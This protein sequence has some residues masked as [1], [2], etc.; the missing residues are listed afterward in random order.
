MTTVETVETTVNTE[1]NVNETEIPEKKHEMVEKDRL[2]H[3]IGDLHKY[4]SQV[5]YLQDKLAAAQEN[6][7]KEKENWKTLY[8]REKEARTL[9]EGVSIKTQESYLSEKKFSA[10]KE[11]AL[12]LGLRPEALD[13]LSLLSL[14]ELQIETTSTGRINVLGADTAVQELKRTRPYWF[15][16]QRSPNVNTTTVGVGAQEG[17]VTWQT[18]QKLEREGKKSGDMLKYREAFSIYNK[19]R[20]G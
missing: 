6:E 15:S 18:L 8:E 19:Q 10:M 9:A 13:D 17:P 16:D 11:S 4:K 2:D 7:L 3:A 12:K 20:G 1:N 14:N 5:K